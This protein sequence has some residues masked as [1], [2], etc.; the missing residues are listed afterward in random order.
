MAKFFVQLAPQAGVPQPSVYVEGDWVQWDWDDGW[1]KI[2]NIDPSAPADA[3]D[4]DRHDTM[5]VF[6][7]GSWLY[8]KEIVE[9]Q[10]TAVADAE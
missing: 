5:A 3:P 7:P 2:Y 4:D 9:D 1:L 8:W 10:P 6:M